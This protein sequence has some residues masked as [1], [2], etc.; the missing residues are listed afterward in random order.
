[1]EDLRNYIKD[2]LIDF[3]DFFHGLLI[4]WSQVRIPH[5]LPNE[6]EGLRE[7]ATPFCFVMCAFLPSLADFGHAVI[8][9][10]RCGRPQRHERLAGRRA[11][12]P[13]STIQRKENLHRDPA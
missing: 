6:F 13:L 1:M 12:S 4:R 11:D 9:L 7:I 5:G 2:K 3:I 8:P 10:P